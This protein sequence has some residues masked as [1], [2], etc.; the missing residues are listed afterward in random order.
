MRIGMKA[1]ASRPTMIGFYSPH[2]GE[3]SQNRDRRG[4]DSC[5]AMFCSTAIQ[6][7]CRAI[8]RACL[9]LLRGLIKGH[10]TRGLPITETKAGVAGLS[11][12]FVLVHRVT[13]KSQ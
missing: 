1:T 5:F 11:R 10:D 9:S 8:R 7:T 3:S 6:H 2:C 13:Y 12:F 4:S